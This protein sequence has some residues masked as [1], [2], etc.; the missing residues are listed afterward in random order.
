M[1]AG[2]QALFKSIGEDGC[3]ALCI[4][5]LG[6]R[7]RLDRDCVDIIEQAIQMKALRQDM[8]VLD[9]AL[10]L[11]LAGGGQWTVRIESATYVPLS[12]EMSVEYWKYTAS[13]GTVYGHFI[14]PDWDSLGESNT[15]KYGKCVSKRI[16]T[17][18]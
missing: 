14:L 6:R 3:Y 15:R 16:F 7:G 17:R 13:D 8:F 12:T 11:S 10:L 1:T 9:P 4:I 18:A 5:E 2:I